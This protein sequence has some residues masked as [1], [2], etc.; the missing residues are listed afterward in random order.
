M[1]I[2]NIAGLVLRLLA[3]A[4][5]LQ[6]LRFKFGAH[7]ESVALFTKLGVEP[8][9]RIFTGV[10]ELIAGVLLIIRPTAIFGAFLAIGLMFGAIASHLFVIGIES[11]GDGGQLFI[12]A[13]IVLLAAAVILL[14]YRKDLK[15]Y[16][17]IPE[18]IQRMV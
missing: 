8:W 13:C 3:A 11:A 14:L 2:Q 1:K 10:V 4:I 5:L 18:F 17:F 9:G 15:K 16:G 6:T 12:L 7:P